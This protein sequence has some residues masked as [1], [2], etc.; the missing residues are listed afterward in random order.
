MSIDSRSSIRTTATSVTSYDDDA[1][2]R[3]G[4]PQP[5]VYSMTSSIRAASYR[6]EYGRGVNNYSDVYWLP[7]DDEELDRLDLQHRM[8]Q[9]L[10]GKY[11]A[12]LHDILKDD[13][14]EDPKRAL[15]LGCGSGGWIMDL[16]RDY[17]H[18][19]C[20]AVDLVPMQREDMPP[21]CRS[22]VDDINFG[23]QH[24]FNAFHVVHARLIS[25]GIRD[26]E[27]LVDHISGALRPGGL[28]DI[29]EFDFRVY[30]PDRKPFTIMPNSNAPY[31]AR[32]MSLLNMAVRQ[33]GGSPDAANSI[34]SY[35]LE[36]GAYEDV[37]YREYFIPTAPFMS[38]RDPNYSYIRPISETFRDDIYAFL[39][40]GRPILLASG[41]CETV[42]DSLAQNAHDELRDARTVSYIRVENVYARKIQQPAP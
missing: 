3:S 5:S 35:V 37:I 14:P 20:V 33:R 27:Y 32:W 34:H 17:P 1:S 36:H 6:H 9:R 16:A 10:M 8:F 41:L 4:S 7:A 12:P 38:K 11:P 24:F 18:C 22:E 31:F 42:V 19:D 23:L 28:V 39:Q 21:N 2:M 30:G 15:D 29:L 13:T 25:S 26:Y 40:S